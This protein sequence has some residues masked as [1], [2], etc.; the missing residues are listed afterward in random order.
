MTVAQAIVETLLRHGPSSVFGYPG[1][2]TVALHAA[3]G[4]EPRLRH[5]LVRHEQAAA[6]AADGFARASG[7][8]GVFLTTAGPGATNALTAVAESYTNSVPTVHLCC[9]VDSR[10]LSRRLGAWHEAD[11]EAVFRPVVKW[12]VTARDAAEA[13]ALVLRALRE[14]ASGRPGPTQV[15]VPRDLLQQS[16]SPVLAESGQAPRES[17]DPRAIAE[18][19]GLLAGAERPVIIAGGGAV[20]AAVGVARLAR[21]LSVGTAVTCMSKGVFPEDD[22]LSLGTSF[23]EA[24]VAAIEEADVC[25]AV[26]CRFT[27]IGTRG[28][29]LRLPEKLIHVDIDPAVIGLHY[30]PRVAITGD[31]AAALAALAEEMGSPRSPDRTAWVARI[32]E[33]RR[34]ETARSAASPEAALC[35]ALREA[36]PREAIVVGDVAGLVYHMFRHFEAYEPRSFLYPAGYIAMGYG[37]PAALGAQLARPDRPVVCLAGDGG[38]SMTG[39]ELATLA[40]YALPIKLVILNNGMLGT[41]AHFGGDDA[42]AL[43]GVIR[44]HNPDFVQFAKAFGIPARQVEASEPGVVGGAIRSLFRRAG[45][46]VLSVCLGGL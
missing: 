39:L 35:R 7:S 44:L 10:F 43:E 16:A 37:L 15:C 11:I 4:R 22:P 29:T 24:A 30:P 17:P 8:V 5:I 3:V 32:A 26:G 14:A 27:Q 38:F 28:W 33:A 20:G 21:S 31:A 18:A 46:A 9:Q 36:I 25:L 42:E 34:A 1:A 45:P 19:A 2:H 41:I 13:P 12:N 23:G 6:F 40:Q